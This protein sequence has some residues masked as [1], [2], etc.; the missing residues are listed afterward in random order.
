MTVK[1]IWINKQ[2][3]LYIQTDSM[4]VTLFADLPSTVNDNRLPTLCLIIQMIWFQFTPNL[5]WNSVIMVH[6]WNIWTEQIATN[7]SVQDG[8]WTEHTVLIIHTGVFKFLI[9]KMYAV[10]IALRN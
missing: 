1:I 2:H 8:A 10:E 4:D 9:F 6:D 7:K 5:T 3:T